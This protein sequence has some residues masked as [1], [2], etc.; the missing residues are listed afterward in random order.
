MT[1]RGGPGS[2]LLLI[3]IL[4]IVWQGLFL[5]AGSDALAAPLATLGYLAEQLRTG[6][7]W[8]HIAATGAAFLIAL[9]ISIAG[10]LAVGLAVGLSRIATEVTEP[11]LLAANSVPKIALYPVVLLIF[12]I[13]M[14]AKIAF[15]AL[16]GII[17]VAIFTMSACR[18]IPAVLLKSAAVM[19]LDG[20]DRIR[21]VLL[22]AALPDIVTGIRIGFSLTLIGTV[23]GEMFGSQSGLGFLLMTA[24]GL[25]NTRVIM[26]VTVLLIAFAATV[27][28]LLLAFEKHLRRR[29]T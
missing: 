7:M 1:H 18:G 19:R 17:P 16:H 2:A 12:G 13:G 26:A 3:A 22:P 20:W 28:S 24:I 8:P 10:G 5:G 11:L 4:L 14:P 25:Q 21:S 29:T 27:S 6:E 9:V 23:L 15:G